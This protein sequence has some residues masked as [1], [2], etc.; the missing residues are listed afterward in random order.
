[1]IQRQSH[2]T[3]FVLDQ[4]EAIKFY[5]ETLGFEIR[6]DFPMTE[7]LRWV[8]VSPKS[9]P[10]LEIVLA[11]VMAG[12]MFNEETA[13]SMRDLVKKGAFGIGVFATDN[14][15]TDYENLTKAGVSFKQAPK[16][17]FYGVEAIA[18][19]NSGNWFSLTQHKK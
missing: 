4:A 6:A 19:D 18:N 15:Q 7:T 14:C 2:T 9:Q 16:E 13:S 1:M 17:T 12:P 11:P 10:D 5:T 3:V 8:T